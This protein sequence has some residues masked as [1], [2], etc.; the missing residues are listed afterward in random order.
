MVDRLLGVA[1]LWRTLG[2]ALAGC[3]FAIRKATALNTIG[4]ATT[5][6]TIAT[7]SSAAST[8]T[9]RTPTSCA[10]NSPAMCC[11]IETATASS[12]RGCWFP[13]RTIRPDIGSVSAVIRGKAREDELEDMLGTVGQTF[14]GV[15]LNCARCH[16]HKF[17]PYTV[18]RLLSSEGGVRGCRFPATG[19]SIRPAD[20]SKRWRFVHDCEQ[21][22]AE[23]RQRLQ[24]HGRK[25]PPATGRQAR[26]SGHRSRRDAAATNRALVVRRQR[27]RFGGQPT[28]RGSRT[29]HG[30]CGG[31]LMVDGQQAFAETPPI[32]RDLTAKT[33]E[34]W[35]Y[36]PTLKQGGGGVISVQTL[37]GHT[38]DAI[39]FAE[40]KP[41]QWMAGSNGF[42]RTKDL[43]GAGETAKPNELIHVAIT[44]AADGQ[45]T[46][47][48]N[49]RPYGDG[50]HAGRFGS[51][52]HLSS[53]ASPGRLWHA[54]H[55]RR[56]SVSA[57]GDRRSAALR[58]RAVA[59]QVRASFQAGIDRISLDGIAGCDERADRQAHK[60]I[61]AEIGRIE[62]RLV[63]AAAKAVNLCC[64]SQ[65]AGADD[66]SC[67]AARSKSLAMPSRLARPRLS[68][69][70]RPSICPANAPE[71]R[72]PPR[73][74]GLGR[75]P[76]QSA[77][78]ARYRQSRLAASFRRRPG[79][80]SQR[81]RFQ[82]RA[83]DAPGI[84]GLA[85]LHFSRVWRADSKHFIA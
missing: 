67:S 39:V 77:D 79:A 81:F 55:W 17:D 50:V 46:V 18:A 26:S 83:A 49:G 57:R 40:R 34:A 11:R 37:D 29:V 45:I 48:R 36:L 52:D 4:S 5:P 78:L 33:L 61:E 60:S 69:G 38:F 15:T 70:R 42:V 24:S 65:A 1:A 84:A 20:E 82:W 10:S 71:G 64:Q 75:S 68:R 62:D 19:R 63:R 73:F 32:A 13:V 35:V 27:Q 23:R 28:R 66:D 30:S 85:C 6:G 76:R 22:V 56:Q 54:P 8:R 51:S 25:S 7:T 14:L 21:Q 9:S 31:R 74:R 80:H 47:F 2:P 41:L 3:R 53:Q 16:D 12:P 72:A 44:Y 43:A 59:E 58:L